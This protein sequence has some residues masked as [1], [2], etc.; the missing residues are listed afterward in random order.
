MDKLSA[1]LR[2]WGPLGVLGVAALDSAGIPLPA[3]VDALLI[4][5]AIL[6]PPEAY[7]S[8]LLAI[9]GSMAGNLLLFSVARKGG[10][11]FLLRHTAS[12]RARKLRLWFQ[13]YGL[14]TVFIPAFVPIV[15]LPLK[16][17]VLSAGALGVSRKAFLLT[18]LAARAPRYLA[19]TYLGLQLGENSIG[20]LQDHVAHLGAVAAGL[21]V[22]LY[23]L[24]KRAAARRKAVAGHL[25]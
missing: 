18:I 4:A 11:A 6:S 20:W 12:A 9:A 10:E 19:L 22:F 7:L 5:V 13:Q 14:I 16:I 8:A 24:V 2:S 21:F 17:F 1:L 3:G 25:R 15:P 23:L